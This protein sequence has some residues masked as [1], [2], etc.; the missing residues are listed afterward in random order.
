MRG[1]FER[2][3]I[4]VRYPR[5]FLALST[6][7]ATGLVVIATAGSGGAAGPGSTVVP[8]G[9]L[10]VSQAK[11]YQSLAELRT[12]GSAVVKVVA[13]GQ[14]F[15]E[16]AGIPTTITTAKV[17]ST[18]WGRAPASTIEIRQLGNPQL[19]GDGVSKLLQPGKTY[20]AFI[21]PSAGAD[22]AAPNRYLIVGESGLYELHGNQYL[23]R[24]RGNGPGES[25]KLQMSLRSGI[26]K[27]IITR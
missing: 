15:S 14:K 22:D 5:I 7:F 26:A 11:T 17:S 3:G 20:L 6:A 25:Q 13:D 4:K 27:T 12:A 19:T 24:G 9:K 18:F 2:K 23:Y 8:V 21:V 10:N 16:V 1:T